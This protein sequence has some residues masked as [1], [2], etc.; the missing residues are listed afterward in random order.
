MVD[1]VKETER[2]LLNEV[3][4][5]QAE[6]AVA[7]RDRTNE[8]ER[9]THKLFARATVAGLGGAEQAAAAS[10]LTGCGSGFELR[11]V[12]SLARR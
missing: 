8:A 1:C 9:G 3:V 10:G 4:E 6:V 7:G 5:R 2:S 12:F 11:L